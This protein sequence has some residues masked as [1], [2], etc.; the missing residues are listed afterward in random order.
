MHCAKASGIKHIQSNMFTFIV[1]ITFIVSK[2]KILKLKI[3][4]NILQF[5]C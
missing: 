1:F 2:F 5:K 4:N 3:S